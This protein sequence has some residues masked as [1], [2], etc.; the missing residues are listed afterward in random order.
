MPLKGK[1][2]QIPLEDADERSINSSKDSKEDGDETQ[3]QDPI[4]GTS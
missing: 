3:H 4:A 1:A 2:L